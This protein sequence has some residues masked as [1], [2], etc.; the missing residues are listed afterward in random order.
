MPVRGAPPVFVSFTGISSV[1]Y[2]DVSLFILNHIAGSCLDEEFRK[3]WVE[4]LLKQLI[5]DA[6]DLDT[7]Q[8]HRERLSYLIEAI[9]KER[10]TGDDASWHL[11]FDLLNLIVELMGYQGMR[12]ERPYVPMYWQS[13]Q[14]HLDF[15]NTRG[16]ADELHEEFIAAAKRRREVVKHLKAQ[17]LTDFDVAMVL[18][19]SEYEVKKLKRNI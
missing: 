11:V 9:Q 16:K 17:G 12:G 1:L 13:L 19:T 2:G 14:A 10:W 3:E 4:R 5:R 18:K 8:E 6:Q 7:T 15:G